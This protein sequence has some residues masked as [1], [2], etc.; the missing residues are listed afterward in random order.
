[1][2][3]MNVKWNLADLTLGAVWDT[4]LQRHERAIREVMLIAQGEL[5]LENFLKQ[6][7]EVWQIYELD[8]ISYQEKA[9]LIKGWDDL[10]NK[11]H[12]LGC[13]SCLF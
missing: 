1:M 12:T 9:H 13:N 4:N 11:V 7:K 10:F 3:Q 2:R 6:V 8:L 5:A